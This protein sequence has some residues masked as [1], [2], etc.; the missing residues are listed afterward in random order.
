MLLRQWDM[1]SWLKTIITFVLTFVLL[2]VVVGCDNGVSLST[3]TDTVNAYFNAVE[4]MD[5]AGMMD[6]SSHTTTS[7]DL[8]YMENVYQM[9][10]KMG[11]SVSFSNRDIEVISQTEDS[12]TV[13]VSFNTTLTFMGE[14]ETQSVNE[15][16]QLIKRDDTWLFTELPDGSNWYEMDIDPIA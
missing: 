10:N 14:T 16:W 9:Y 1:S 7:D 2:V 4:K 3:P 13:S 6:C 15:T 12:A 5:A 8:Q 11:M